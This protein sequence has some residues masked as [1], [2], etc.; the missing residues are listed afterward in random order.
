M[1]TNGDIDKITSNTKTIKYRMDDFDG[2]PWHLDL[3]YF[4]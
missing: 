2:I 4:L 3:E 1:A